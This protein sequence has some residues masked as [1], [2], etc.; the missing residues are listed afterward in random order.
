MPS[1]RCLRPGRMRERRA[2]GAQVPAAA[3]A[4]GQGGAGGRGGGLAAAGH[5][6]L[7]HE[8]RG[9][10]P[11]QQGCPRRP[12]AGLLGP[13]RRRQQRREWR[14]DRPRPPTRSRVTTACTLHPPCPCLSFASLGDYA[15]LWGMPAEA[16]SPPRV[17]LHQGSRIRERLAC[18]R[19]WRAGMGGW[20]LVP[21]RPGSRRGLVSGL[22]LPLSR[23]G[24]LRQ[25]R[26][27]SA[28]TFVR[29]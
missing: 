20:S 12:R 3:A 6:G 25:P 16:G 15:L 1:D 2:A 10:Q 26:R 29:S 4:G 8:D 13:C 5:G 22:V 17:H 19:A 21:W 7:P 23:P 18:H 11:H 28:R 27:A 14:R 24:S 9:R